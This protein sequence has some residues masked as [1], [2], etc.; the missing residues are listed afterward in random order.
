M[1]EKKKNL[2]VAAP[3]TALT[4]K[5]QKNFAKGGTTKSKM[6]MKKMGKK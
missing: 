6:T 3:I 1:A 4:R 2:V 5:F